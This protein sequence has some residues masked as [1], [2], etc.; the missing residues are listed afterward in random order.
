MKKTK[1]KKAS[2]D[3]QTPSL[4][5]REE[6]NVCT[7]KDLEKI[8]KSLIEAKKKN[9]GKRML[10]HCH[11]RSRV[12]LRI[13]SS[14]TRGPMMP[15]HPFF[16][17]NRGNRWLGSSGLQPISRS[18]SIAFFSTPP[19]DIFS[20]GTNGPLLG[21][22]ISTPNLP[23]ARATKANTAPSATTMLLVPAKLSLRA[24]SGF[25]KNRLGR[26]AWTS[27]PKIS[28]QRRSCR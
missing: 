11:I 25:C 17:S 13:T 15:K 12:T 2:P 21:G 22:A 9:H 23:T 24:K 5:N 7:I 14:P 4:G 28:S 3:C 20:G 1:K 19:M 27:C 8:P 18:R 16:S 26:K 6:G 10:S